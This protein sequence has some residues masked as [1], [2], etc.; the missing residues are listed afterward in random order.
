MARQREMQWTQKAYLLMQEMRFLWSSLLPST[1]CNIKMHMIEHMGI[2]YP[3]CLVKTYGENKQSTHQ[4]S[5]V[6][7]AS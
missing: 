2:S 1:G 3:Q 7:Q 4:T 5:C 6:S